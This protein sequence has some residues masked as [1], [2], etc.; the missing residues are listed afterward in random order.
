MDMLA[1]DMK[2]SASA[3]KASELRALAVAM[4]QLYRAASEQWPGR[5]FTQRSFV[6]GDVFTVE[7]TRA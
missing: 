7:L 6:D 2:L 5:D 3:S 4:A 1:I